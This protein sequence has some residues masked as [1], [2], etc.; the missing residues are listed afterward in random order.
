MASSSTSSRCLTASVTGTHNLEVTSYSLLEG[1]GVG[2]FVSSTTFSVAGYDW[3]LRF[4]PD[5]ITDNDRKEGYVSASLH[6]V[7]TTTG[8]MPIREHAIRRI[9]FTGNDSF[10]IECSLT[11]ISESRAEDVSTIPVPPSNL[12]QHLAGM[13]HGVEI[14]D[15]EFSVGGEPFRAHACV[16]AARSPV[17]RAELL[18][19][20]AARSIKIDDDDDM[21]PATFKALLHF[22]YT[23]HLPNDSGF[24]KDAAMQRR[25]LVAAD[26]YGVD[27]LRAMCEAKL[28]ES[29]SV[30]TVVDSLEFAEKHHCAQLKDACLGF[31]AS[32]NVLGV[33]RKTDGFKRLVEGCPWVLKEILDKVELVWFC[34]FS[35]ASSTASPSDGRSPRLPETLSR[36]V[37]ASVAAA[38][39]FEVT[40][41]SL[42][43]GV[44]AGEFVTSG[45]FSVDGHDWNIQVY[46]DGW[47]QEMNAGYVS[48]FLCLCGGA[49]GVRA[50]YTLSLSENGGESV[51]RSLTHR[52]D[53]VGAFWGFPRFME[54]PRLRQ[55]LL[56]RGPG[57]GDDC[58]TFRCALTVIR[59]PRTEGVAAVAVPPSDMRR[60]MAN[61]LRGGDGADVVVLVRD[62]PF[63]AHRCVLAA[64]SPVFRAELFG[65]G[66]M[67]ERRTSCV[68]VDDM[69][70]SIFS[71]FLHFIY[72]DSLPENPD[73]PGDDQDCMAMQH[74]MVAADRYGLDRLVLICEEKLCRGIDVQTVATTLALAE[75]HQR[76]ALKDACLGFIVSRGVLGAVARTDGFKHLLTT[77]PSIM[78]DILDKVASVMSNIQLIA[79]PSLYHAASAAA[80]GDHRD[81]AFPAAAGGCRLPKTSSVSVTE[82]V[83]AVHDFKVTGYSLIEGLGIGRY[84]SSSTFTVGGVDWAVRFYPDGSTV[85]CLGNASAFLYYCGREKEVRTR[86]TLN[87]L[88][89]DGKLSQV[90]NSYMKHTFSPAS[91][92]WGFIK[93]AEKSKLQSS[94]FL[95]NDCLTIRC[96]LTVVRESHTKDVEVNSV[97]VPPSNLHTDFENMLQDGEGSDVT[98]TVGGQE[99]RAHRCV[100]AFRSPVFKAELFGPMKENGTQCIKIDDMEPEVFEAL[101][102]FI[103]TDRLPDSCRDGKAAAMQHLLVAADRYGVDRLRLICERR[104]SETIDVETVATTLV[105]AEQ[106]HCSQLRRACIGFVASPNMLGPVIESDGF[107]H[108]VESCPLIMKEILNMLTSS[109]ARTSSRSVWEGIT[110]THDFEVVG[111][112][113]MDGFGAGRHVCSG[114]F[115]VAG[116]D[117]Y[118]AFYPDGL[119]QDSAGYASACLAYRGKERL[120]RAKYSLSLVARDGRASPLAGD[121]LRSHY[122]TPTSRSADVLK[123]VE[124]SKLSSS[125]SSSSYSCLD[126]DTLTIRCVVTVVTGPRVESV[127]PAKERGPRVTVPPPSLHEHLAR[128]LRD[129]RGSDVA[130]RVGGRVLRAHRCVL[131]A[132]SPVFDAELLG[133]MMET[134][135]PCIEIHG[136]EPAAFEALLRFV[137]TDSWPLAGVDVA[138]TVRLLSAADR[139]G[140]ERLRLMCEEKLHEGIDVDNAA[141]VLA[142]AELHHCSQ[143]RDACVAFI[144]SPSTLGPVLASSGFEDLIMATGASVTKEILHKVSESW[145]GPGNRNNSSKR[146]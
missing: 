35:M 105:L 81:P 102:H 117:W 116:H 67:R 88:G 7:G 140:L 14:A 51:Q 30:G 112:S 26:R 52:F 8:A 134:T 110:G 47:K 83:T 46:P 80:M 142:M 123:F 136:V 27:R 137:Y 101:L 11:V 103:Y 78:V 132:R 13:L 49:T 53:T 15:V 41:Y 21:E 43:A 12:H 92:N 119:D 133:P 106:H 36:C 76:V 2:K 10:K 135:A 95:H 29:V 56:R 145:S 129:G 77:C 28:Y 125:P 79:P 98:F 65:G 54:R 31:M 89:K 124:K 66:H 17:F 40:R 55:W 32:P 16:L 141:D 146:K 73:T 96:L 68:V 4:Y 64:R 3:N 90:T 42:L 82:S 62:Q 37:T 63:R 61:M 115:S 9:R 144:A 59:E 99:F 108:L 126:D 19:P 97:V 48:V 75:Q 121:T 114:D 122:F 50:K 107:K 70:P 138:A 58:V 6:L 57:G 44:G 25:L 85:T 127:A 72:T 23:D 24:G 111:Y 94:P 87:L 71:A 104:L 113:L 109:A 86:F 38:H 22:I 18:G 143:L 60:H 84:V 139:Y 33:V 120:V 131:A 34:L 45:A 128:M 91:D 5:G 20:A 100:L 118:V 1:M 69:E 130:F 39:N 74:L 93:F